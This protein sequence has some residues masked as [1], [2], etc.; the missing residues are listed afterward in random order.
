MFPRQSTEQLNNQYEQMIAC[1][2]DQSMHLTV[3]AQEESEHLREQLERTRQLHKKS[4]FELDSRE[5][6]LLALKQKLRS[7]TQLIDQKDTKI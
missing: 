1:K 6:E 7:Q 2:L 3:Q 5:D 4:Q